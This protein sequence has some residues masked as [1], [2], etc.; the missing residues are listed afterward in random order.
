MG[1]FD[2]RN[3]SLTLMSKDKKICINGLAGCNFQPISF[4]RAVPLRNS[5]KVG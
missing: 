5:D 2:K 1:T 3:N 4:M